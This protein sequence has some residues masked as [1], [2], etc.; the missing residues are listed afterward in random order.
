MALLQ[1]SEPGMSTAPHQRRLAVGIDLG[2]T[3]SLV[4]TVRSSIP[5]VLS[6][7]DGRTLLPSVVRYLP[8]G[9]ANIGYKAQAAQTTDPKN[10]IVS[11]K[12]FMGR[13]LKDIAHAEN[14]PYDFQDAPGMVQ[15][16][17]V[18]GVK[19]PVEVSAQI[20]ATLRQRAEDALGD[21]LVGAVITVPAYFDDAQRQATK[22][23]A[24]LAGL[25]VLRLLNEPTAAAIAYGLDSASEGVY[26]VYDLGG[27]TFDISVLKL[28]K[29]VFEV[30]S[31]GG[32]SALGGDDFDHRL[33]CWI[34]EQ[35]QLSPLSDSDTR[36]LLVKAREVKELLSTQ[37]QTSIDVVLSSQ[38]E[39]HLTITAET[40]VEITQHLVAKTINVIRKSLRDADI[41]VDD[42]DGVVMVGGA[43]RMPHVRKA[44]GEFFQTLPLAN[45]DPDKVVA[46]GAAVQANLLAGNRAAGEEWLLLD[47]IPLSLG[48]E[49]MGGLAEKVIP[50]NSTIPCARAQ[51]FTTFKDGQTAMAVHVVQGER[52]LV[53]DCRS[54]ARFELRGIPPMVAGAARIRVTYQVDAD[55]LLA[56]SAREMTSGV[57]ASIVVKPSYGL[58]DDQIAKML[59]DSFAF[60]DVDMQQRALKEERVEAERVVLATKAALSEDAALLS[61]EE[62][63]AIVKLLDHVAEKIAGD[64]HLVIKA[65]VDALAH[66]TEEF[67]ARRMDRSVHSALA[68]KT[69]DEI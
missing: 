3:N 17:T 1:I 56:V 62:Q 7:E 64:D 32:D 46:L 63:V 26:A 37:A 59:Q 53:D 33:F 25:N 31:T 57:E 49:T 44:I 15:L 10:T 66:G 20:L 19:S 9:H 8:N 27:G 52:E 40:F 24:Q 6:D 4:A 60:A 65:A 48:I 55:G 61:D 47:V 18:A 42:V 5:E 12:R 16:K 38:E 54:L 39:V 2:T 58:E 13:G 29:G 22:D 35:A 30:L 34:S 36:T 67:A 23:A 50:R 14:L 41:G 51:E 69:L 21:D 43:T 45:I 11:V 68:G 28:S